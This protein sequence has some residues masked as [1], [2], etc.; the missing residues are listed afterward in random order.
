MEFAIRELVAVL[1]P[2]WALS[3]AVVLE[4]AVAI[5][6]VEQRHEAVNVLLH[7]NMRFLYIPER[8]IGLHDLFSSQ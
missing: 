4:T 8:V 6:S 2:P 7:Q 3:R 1:S 5:S